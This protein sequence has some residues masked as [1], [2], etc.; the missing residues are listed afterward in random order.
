M[1]KRFFCLLCFGAAVGW[2]WFWE[3]IR[4]L[5]YEQG[6]RLLTPVFASI[7]TG[8]LLRWGPTVGLSLLGFYLFWKTRP[9][10]NDG[11]DSPKLA[12]MDAPNPLQ[13]V[14]GTDRNF[15]TKRASGLYQMAHTFSV[16]VKNADSARFLSN[17]KLYLDISNEGNGVPTTYLLVDTF[18]LN[19]PEERFIPIVSYDEPATISQHVGRH[20]RLLIP[21]HAGYYDVGIGWP[22]QMPIGAY[23]FT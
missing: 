4:S 19:A 2:N 3:F 8:D 15:E 1:R 21:V 14:F 10:G 20:I 7:T 16:A 5:F 17:F 6:S 11:V 18:T 22:W 9:R 12:V 13:I 23:T